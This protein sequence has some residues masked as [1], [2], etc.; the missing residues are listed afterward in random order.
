MG[1]V[2]M[3]GIYDCFGYGLGY[4]VSFEERY[5]LIKNA[6]FDWAINS[7]GGLVIKRTFNLLEMLD[8]I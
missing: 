4:D 6:G 8:Y 1:D 7:V 3:I 2:D 5:R